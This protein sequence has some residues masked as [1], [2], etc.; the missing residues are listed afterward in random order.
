M[1]LNTHNDELETLFHT[2]FNFNIRY[3]RNLLPKSKLLIAE[4]IALSGINDQFYTM[5][6][7]G[8]LIYQTTEEIQEGLDNLVEQEYISY[9]I[10]DNHLLSC[11]FDSTAL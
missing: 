10:A 5:A 1:G 2:T 8:D 7:V 3:D 4:L 9:T 11:S 6:E